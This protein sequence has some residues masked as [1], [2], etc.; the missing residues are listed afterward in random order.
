MGTAPDGAPPTSAPKSNDGIE[1]Q[2]FANPTIN[3]IQSV[4][5]RTSTSAVSSIS[6]EGTPPPLPPRP[7]NRAHFDSRPSTS[8]STAPARP[9]LASKPTTQLSYVG[10][11]THSNESKD[12]TSSTSHPKSYLGLNIDRGS[13]DGDDSASVRSFAPTIEAGGETGGDAESILGEIIGDREKTLLR[14]LGHRFEDKESASMFSPDQEFEEAFAH[15]FDEIED[16]RPDG[17]NEGQ[18]I[19]LYL[20]RS[21]VRVC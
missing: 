6:R 7:K 16:M 20:S 12:E 4:S 17:S 19:S 8:H 14:S 3:I 13:N 10:S 11:Q 2:D 1:Q 5:R 9:H 15:E 18:H 21:S